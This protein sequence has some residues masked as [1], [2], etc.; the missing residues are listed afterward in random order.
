MAFLRHVILKSRKFINFNA[1]M[2]MIR[3]ET[4]SLNAHD[5]MRQSKHSHIDTNLHVLRLET[6][7]SYSQEISRKANL[8]FS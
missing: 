8:G 6:L 7:Y 1:F 4:L 2:Q 3:K 5:T